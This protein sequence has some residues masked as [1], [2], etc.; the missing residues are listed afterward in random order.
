[1]RIRS[2]KPEF[3]ASDD[4]AG[5]DRDTRLLFIGLWSYVD[6]N[7]VGR[8]NERLIVADIFPLEQDPREILAT[9]SRGLQALFQG[10]Q[11]TR[12]KVAGRPFLFVNK[13]VEHQKIDRPNKGRYPLPTC[14]DAVI[15]DILATPS[16]DTRED[17]SPGAVEQRNRGTEE[18]REL[19]RPTTSSDPFETFWSTY[20]RRDAKRKAEGAFRAALKRADAQTITAGAQR[21]ADDPNREAA[22]TAMPATW[23][24]ADRWGDGPIPSRNG[25]IRGPTESAATTGSRAALERAARYAAEDQSDRPQIGA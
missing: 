25:G 15:R 20:P 13:W 6:D 5:H 12:Y 10:G 8:D 19:H 14:N 23:L 11:I 24:N 16:R 21:Y 3:W 18:K 7:G 4:M 2:I 22:F 1:M 9:V 17:S